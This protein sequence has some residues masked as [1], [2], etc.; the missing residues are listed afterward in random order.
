[1]K[2]LAWVTGS[3]EQVSSLSMQSNKVKPEK[4][5]IFA[6][7]LWRRAILSLTAP[8]SPQ[9]WGFYLPPPEQSSLYSLGKLMARLEWED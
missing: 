5:K 8:L 6:F 3:Q 9:V 4:K 7:K 1:M 2:F